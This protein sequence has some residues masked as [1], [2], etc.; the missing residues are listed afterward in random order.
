MRRG[1]LATG[2]SKCSAFNRQPPSRLSS[3]SP[4]GLVH[5]TCRPSGPRQ[6]LTMVSSTSATCNATV[7]DPAAAIALQVPAAYAR[8]LPEN[9]DCLEG[10]ERGYRRKRKGRV[11]DRKP[12][13]LGFLVGRG[14]AVPPVH[15]KL[16]RR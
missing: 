13:Q 11:E 10:I 1:Y 16:P 5:R 9:Q 8:R 14:S 15:R 6:P 4:V 3:T 2:C 12:G 7:T